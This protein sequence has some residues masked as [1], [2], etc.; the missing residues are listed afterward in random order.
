ML[1]HHPPNFFINPCNDPNLKPESSSSPLGGSM[2]IA[3][4][5]VSFIQLKAGDPGVR[6][7]GPQAFGR[8]PRAMMH[9]QHTRKQSTKN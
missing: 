9:L 7:L 4:S 8:G 3:I 5:A 1:L 6:S 2:S